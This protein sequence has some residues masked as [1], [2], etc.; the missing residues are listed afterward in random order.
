MN[1]ENHEFLIS[2][3]IRHSVLLNSMFFWSMTSVLPTYTTNP[4]VFAF[5]GNAFTG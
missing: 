2:K 4:H 5:R 3:E 1:M